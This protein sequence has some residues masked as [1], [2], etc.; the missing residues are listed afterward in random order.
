[1]RQTAS[2]P[3]EHAL[4]ATNAEVTLPVITFQAKVA[5]HIPPQQ[6]LLTG[7]W[8]TREGMCTVLLVTPEVLPDNSSPKQVLC[9][10]KWIEAPEAVL[11]RLMG[12]FATSSTESAVRRVLT[13][14]QTR[15]LLSTLE[16]TQGVNLLSSPRVSNLAGTPAQI[17][18]TQTKE[19]AGQNFD[20]GNTVD[21]LSRIGADG[22]G[23]DLDVTA[24]L[25][26][27]R[28]PEP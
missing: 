7:G 24:R 22:A 17:S 5:V 13:E 25:C 16:Q 10:A 21:L 9:Q 2:Q 15:E 6:S 19:I 11:T 18:T 28:N 23:I 12:E 14:A 20:I 26:L 8:P 1:M 4:A 3:S 27:P